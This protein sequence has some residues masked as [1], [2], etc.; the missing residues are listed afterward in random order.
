M[1]NKK[2]IAYLY[3][4]INEQKDTNLMQQMLD[5]HINEIQQAGIKEVISIGRDPRWGLSNYRDGIHPSRQGN[6]VLADIIA[7]PQ[8]Q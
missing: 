6:S 1:K 3:P 8:V 2:V 5:S 7:N 4:D